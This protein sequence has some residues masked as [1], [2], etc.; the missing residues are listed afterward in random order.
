[1]AG[2]AV[3]RAE[4]TGARGAQQRLGHDLRGEIL[5]RPRALGQAVGHGASED[6]GV[7]WAHMI[8]LPN[9]SPNRSQML[10]LPRFFSPL[11]Q[12]HRF[13]RLVWN[14]GGRAGFRA[15]DLC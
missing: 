1:M 5:R 14:P 13:Q 9:P 8:F 3:E 2:V 7:G 15:A 6:A 12:L 4:R 11:P 10:H